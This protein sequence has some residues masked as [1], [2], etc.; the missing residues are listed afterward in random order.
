VHG[1]LAELMAQE[2]GVDL[3]LFEGVAHSDEEIVE[4]L[5]RGQ[6]LGTYRRLCGL[7]LVEP[8]AEMVKADFEEG[9]E[10]LV[11]FAHHREVIEGLRNL[12]KPFNPV[13]LYGGMTP[14]AKQTAMN[15]YNYD[16][17]VGVFIGQIEACGTSIDLPTGAEV[18]FAEAS[19]TPADNAQAFARVD[20]PLAGQT[21][22]VRAR[23]PYIPETVH[24][25]ITRTLRRKTEA[26]AQLY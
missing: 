1:K 16:P 14:N 19:W 25:Q 7:A 13:I 20:R 23:W 5:A 15:S 4:M 8:I 12:L 10:K 17:K 9:V 2:S 11:I 26:L 3:S 24:E 21:R 18:I 6:H 22:S